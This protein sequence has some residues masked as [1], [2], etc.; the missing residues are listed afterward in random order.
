ML[1]KGLS[2]S[3]NPGLNYGLDLEPE[4]LAELMGKS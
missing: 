4:M 2:I 1:W 3:L